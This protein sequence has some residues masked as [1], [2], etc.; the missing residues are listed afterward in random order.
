MHKATMDLPK[1]KALGVDGIP[2][3]FF[4]EMWQGVGKDIKNLCKRHFKKE[5]CTR[6][7]RLVYNHSSQSQRIIVLSLIIDQF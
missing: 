5:G 7:L 1:H 6:N 3:E 2:M 4:H